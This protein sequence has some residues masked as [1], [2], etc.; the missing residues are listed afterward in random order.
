MIEVPVKGLRK[1]FKEG[2]HVKVIGEAD[3]GTRLVWWCGS[4]M[5]ELHF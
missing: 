1:R 5:T 2:D 4:K 3:L